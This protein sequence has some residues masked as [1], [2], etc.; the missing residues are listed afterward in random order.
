[1]ATQSV[2]MIASSS[3]IGLTMKLLAEFEDTVVAESSA[4][5][6]V[7]DPS[8]WS[9]TFD[10]PNARYRCVLYL[11]AKP[12]ASD[13]VTI[14]AASG[15]YPTD[16]LK[17]GSVLDPTQPAVTFGAITIDAAESGANITLAG[18]G[19]GDGIAWT[20]AGT[21]DPVNADIVTQLQAGLDTSTGV[22][23]VFVDENYGG[24]GNLVYQVRGTIV[25]G[26]D[27]L[28]YK[29]SDYNAGNRG[30]TYVIAAGRQR[31]DGR[32]EQAVRLNPGS[33]KMQ[34]FKQGVAGPDTFDLVVE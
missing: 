23:T 4:S 24:T 27:I 11:A 25:D 20:R 2:K 7:A 3:F 26:A 31:A 33:Y 18:S 15:T 17:A 13:F 22:G 16:S 30:N 10:V 21:G 6:G 12:V 14:L 32:W 9:A 8:L 34:F 29:A 1:M 28:I 5:K 19:S